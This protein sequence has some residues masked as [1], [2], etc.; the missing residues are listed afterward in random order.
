MVVRRGRLPEAD[1]G[2]TAVRMLP[3][4]PLKPRPVLE[5][6][7]REAGVV[8]G[9]G[10]VSDS[11]VRRGAQTLGMRFQDAWAGLMESEEWP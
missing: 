9:C 7:E 5:R 4:P 10:G 3:S 11:N 1:E 6:E 8:R 2:P